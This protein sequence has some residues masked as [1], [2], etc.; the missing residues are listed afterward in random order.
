MNL[1]ITYIKKP[2][3]GKHEHITHCGNTSAR[4]ELSVA[5]IVY[6]I[7]AKI[8]SFYVQDPRTGKVAYVGVV[9]SSNHAPYLRTYADNTWN[10]NLLSLPNLSVQDR[11]Y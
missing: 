5:D 10:D 9:R 3:Q 4:W 7:E 2:V 11:V 6:R 1:Q 8:D